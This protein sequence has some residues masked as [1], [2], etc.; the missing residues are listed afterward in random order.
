MT[1]RGY[2]VDQCP[3][4]LRYIELCSPRQ[5]LAFRLTCQELAT[6]LDFPEGSGL[7]RNTRTWKQVL[8]AAWEKEMFGYTPEVVPALDGDGFEIIFRSASHLAPQQMSEVLE[9]SHAYGA[10][11]GL[12]FPERR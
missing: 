8:V 3:H 9:F 1:Q 11:R 5:R 10:G 6:Q 4:C 12:I 7:M 2:L